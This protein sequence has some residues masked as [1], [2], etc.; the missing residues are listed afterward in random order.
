MFVSLG[1]LVSVV[2]L[3]WSFSVF[4]F[5]LFFLVLSFLAFVCRVPFSVLS[6]FV[7]FS[8][9]FLF[10]LLVGLLV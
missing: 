7:L 10:R 4:V 1:R 9:R 6:F 3:L 5:V 8:V 2:F